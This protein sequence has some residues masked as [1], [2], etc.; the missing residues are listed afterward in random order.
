MNLLEL[1]QI[2]SS[3]EKS[4]EFLCQKGVLKTFDSC[5]LCNAKNIGKIR[6]KSLKCYSCRTEWSVRKENIL[7][8]LKIPF[9]K[10]ILA[11]KLSI[12]EVP[13]NKAYKELDSA[14]NTTN[15]IY[16]QSDFVYS[17]LFQKTFRWGDRDG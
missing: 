6:G 15:K 12:L 10:F 16:S 2:V 11:V 14:Y 8:D 17:D 4:E 9:S 3:E 7:Q 1:L 5:P 13:V